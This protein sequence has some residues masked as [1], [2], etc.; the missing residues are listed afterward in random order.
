MS[1]RS[2]GFLVRAHRFPAHGLVAAAVAAALSASYSSATHAQEAQ[3]GNE[4]EEVTVTGSRIVRRDLDAPTPVVTVEREQFEQSAF[5]SVDQVL[6][7]LPQFVTGAINGATAGLSGEFA[8]GDVQPSAT[9]SP[10]A[11][12]INLRGLG[13]NRSLTL[14]DGRRGQPSNATLVIDLNTIPSSAIA[15]VEVISGG[16]SAVYGAD[17]LAGVTNFKLRDNFQGVEVTARGGI[18]EAGGDGKD[19]QISSL[20]GTSLSDKGNA[21]VAFEWYRRE[22][23]LRSNRDWLTDSLN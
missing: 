9:N 18:N 11:A 12:T 4:L 19:W 17:A 7:E 10:G 14:I 23:A 16:A 15:S 8:T 2:S 5:T 22:S 21:M 3:A 1:R 6:N 13:T 20:L